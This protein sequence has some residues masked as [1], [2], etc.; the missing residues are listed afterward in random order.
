MVLQG[1][2]AVQ[3]GLLVPVEPL[4]KRVVDERAEAADDW[5][6]RRPAAKRS[7]REIA[8]PGRCSLGP[9][10]IIDANR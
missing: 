8:A 2:V 6:A 9:R 5:A 4:T 3:L 10:V 7:P 1:V